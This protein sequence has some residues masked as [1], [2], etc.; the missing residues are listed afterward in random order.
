MSAGFIYFFNTAHDVEAMRMQAALLRQ[1]QGLR[2]YESVE[3]LCAAL[4]SPEASGEPRLVLLADANHSA[5]CEAARSL[6][7]VAPLMSVAA[8]LSDIDSDALL[9]AMC[10]GVDAC[11][12]RDAPVQSVVSAV[13]RLMG[14]HGAASGCHAAPERPAQPSWRLVSGAWVVQAPQGTCVTLTTAE[15]ALML[16]LCSA[17]GQRLGYAQLMQAVDGSSQGDGQEAPGQGRSGYA[18]SD[19]RRLSVLV[20]RL[21]HKFAGAGI[22]IP[23]R[24]LRRMGYE[25]SMAS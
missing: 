23:I 17:P 21:R 10:S 1:G 14:R 8:L 9:G 22:E 13:L 5:N 4:A 16:A 12:P 19:A 25:I 11:W 3:V 20:S 18:R 6:R 24:S 7:Q 2:L 15:R